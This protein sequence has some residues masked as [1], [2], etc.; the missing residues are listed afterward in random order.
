MSGGLKV[1]SAGVAD[2]GDFDPNFLPRAG[3][4][5]VILTGDSEG[6]RAVAWRLGEAVEVVP[7]GHTE[8]RAR[9]LESTR[10]DLEALLRDALDRQVRPCD[11]TGIGLPGCRTCD[12]RVRDYRRELPEPEVRV[13]GDPPAPALGMRY[14]VDVGSGIVSWLPG[15]PEGWLGVSGGSPLLEVADASGRVLWR[16]E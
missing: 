11:H 1:L 16:R 4:N 15:R 9:V 14:R 13:G 6:V 8:G 7:V 12:P 5:F 3:D 2:G 10:R